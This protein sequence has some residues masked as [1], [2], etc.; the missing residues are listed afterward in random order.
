[1]T[2]LLNQVLANK[3]LNTPNSAPFFT[4]DSEGKVKPLNPKGYLLPSKIFASPV[5]YAK[6][7]KK[8]V[9]NIGKAAKGK[10]NDHELGRINDLGV[11][12]GSLAIAAYLCVK[13]PLKLNKVMQFVGF[14]SFFASMA[15]LPKLLIQAPLKA[16]TG[17]DIHQKYVDSQGRKK[18]LFQDPQYD[19]TDLYSQEDLDRIGK[20]LNVA[21][22]LPDRNSFIKQRAKKVGVQGNTLWM[23]SAGAAP[24]FSAL[25]S[26]VAEKG[27]N[28]G[29]EKSD[30]YLA[31]KNIDTKLNLKPK[32]IDAKNINHKN[33]FEKL[34]DKFFNKSYEKFIANNMEAPVDSKMAKRIAAQYG[35][36]INSAELQSAI[37]KEIL[38]MGMPESITLDS[39]KNLLKG[40]VSEDVFTNL[41]E[42]Q[43]KILNESI[44]NNS[45]KSI[46]EILSAATGG[47]KRQQVKLGN[48]IAEVIAGAKKKCDT[49]KISD[50]KKALD[51]LH[52]SMSDFSYNKN[53]LDKYIS[54]VVGDKSGS[55]IANQWGRFTNSAVKALGLSSKELKELSQGNTKILENKL[56]ELASNESLYNSTMDKLIKLVN[57]YEAKTGKAFTETVESKTKEICKDAKRAFNNEGL[58]T[59]A[60]KITTSS[61]AEANEIIGTLENS[62]NLN[63][64][65]RISGASSSFYRYIQAL[66]VFKNAGNGQ[67]ESQITELLKEQLQ[68][69]GSE[70]GDDA[71]KQSA[72]KLVEVCK[73]VILE[74]S[75]VDYVEKLKSSGF[76]LS[77]VEYKTVMKAL[78]DTNADEN[79]VKK[80]LSGL[81]KYKQEVMQKIA[82]WQ[83]T[84]TPELSRRV[85]D[86]ATNS[87][88]AA[89]R[90]N[91]AGKPIKAMMQD[92]AK[93]IYNSNK[94]FKIWMGASIAIVAATIT[95]G[96]LIGRKGKTEKEV[97]EQNKTNG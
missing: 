18:M 91:L 81:S 79:M 15:L 94:W 2:N 67:L 49:P 29:L 10:A 96:L 77:E 8:D 14:G 57:D 53:I 4:F 50:I 27:I 48:E 6:D 64:K 85:I 56:K 86:T 61:K 44:K 46:G 88:N 95:A 32:S 97:E 70:F 5:D 34:K 59:I 7:I 21:E 33:V 87:A 25:I 76:E 58:H 19:L 42:D 82:N 30:M 75:T 51:G 55:Y 90:N 39:I 40:K 69:S 12:I 92:A 17:V 65:N 71:L 41:T 68:K 74:A 35:T 62:I 3:P 63:V 47:N 28:I 23:M 80:G 73:K 66:E 9:L 89:E 11:K 20:K 78:F 54:S 84:I 24:I 26:N 38:S 52:N 83:N 93:Q 37:E 1:M 43:V 72:K 60:N 22:N 45:F 36:K 31:K 13:N 16:R